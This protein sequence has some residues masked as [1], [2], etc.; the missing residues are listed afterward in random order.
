MVWRRISEVPDDSIGWLLAVARHVVSGHRRSFGRR[1]ELLDR[2]G[3]LTHPRDAKH[4]P[5][6]AFDTDPVLQAALQRLSA[7]DR[8]ALILDA[9][10]DVTAA[11]AAV[12]QGCTPAT[13]SVRL[14][15]ARKRVREALQD[16]SMAYSEQQTPRT[17]Q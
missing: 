3:R 9:W 8:E 15:R 17:G 6:S 11:Q 14:H 2:L 4:D 10:L 12:V 1:A 16:E 7:S 5:V 13:Y